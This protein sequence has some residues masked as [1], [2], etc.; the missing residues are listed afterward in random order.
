MPSRTPAQ[1]LSDILENI[2]NV[3]HFTSGM[4]YQDFCTDIKTCYAVAR[5]F[6]IISEASRRLP[7]DLKARRP[8]I[9]WPGLAALGNV[10]RHQYDLVIEEI[11]WHSLQHELEPLDR[12]AMLELRTLR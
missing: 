11:M 12:V 8:D 3:R 10:Y 2:R 5:A 1:R 7:E 4:T 6:E 9:D